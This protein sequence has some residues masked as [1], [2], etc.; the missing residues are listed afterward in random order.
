MCTKYHTRD[1]TLRGVYIYPPQGRQPTCGGYMHCCDVCISAQKSVR[2]IYSQQLLCYYAHVAG[3]PTRATA[4]VGHST[5]VCTTT[6]FLCRKCARNLF[7]AVVVLLCT[8]SRCTYKGDSLRRALYRCV[9]NYAFLCTE[10]AS[11]QLCIATRHL[12]ECITRAT[13]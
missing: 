8:C 4:Y 11:Q 13:A 3:A 5:G 6:H 10:I 7:A 12:H 1:A 9:H 2:T